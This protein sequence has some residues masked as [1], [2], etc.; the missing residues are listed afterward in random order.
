MPGI[1]F[2]FAEISRLTQ[3][4]DDAIEFAEALRWGSVVSC[5]RCAL[6]DVARLGGRP[7]RYRC[8][9]CARQFSIR[10]GTPME[11]SHLPVSV[12][13]RALWLI[14]SSSKGVSSLKLAE[15]LG[16]QQRSAWFLAHRV[17]TMMAWVV[18]E[19]ISGD[20]VELDEVYAGAP[21]RQKTGGGP[22]GVPTGRGP[23]RPLVPTAVA[24]GREA[25]FRFIESHG[26]GD[27]GPRSDRLS[28]PP[29]CS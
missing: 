27:I 4:E 21:P 16:I 18:R 8:R 1:K 25:R 19:P 11:S 24:R 20:I 13:L 28:R 9:A 12:W 15:M 29:E 3:T 22:T 10:T 2:T 26:K 7:G 17:R 6:A 5:H 14:I 23:R